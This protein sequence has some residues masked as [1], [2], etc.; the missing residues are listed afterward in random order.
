[1]MR[2]IALVGLSTSLLF[3]LSAAL[4]KTAAAG[5]WQTFSPR[6][7]APY[8]AD[9]TDFGQI[10]QAHSISSYGNGNLYMLGCDEAYQYNAHVYRYDQFG[11]GDFADVGGGYLQYVS[12]APSG[13]A[14]GVTNYLDG[15]KVWFWDGWNWRP[16]LLPGAR[17]AAG[18]AA[19]DDSTAFV[20]GGGDGDRCPG[21][22]CVYWT[23]NAGQSWALW[24]TDYDGNVGAMDIVYDP[25]TSEPW[26]IEDSG[27]VFAVGNDPYR[28]TFLYDEGV[29]G[30]PDNGSLGALRIAAANGQP[31]VIANIASNAG[32]PVF[33]LEGDQWSQVGTISN[34]TDISVD[35]VNGQ[36]WVIVLP[37]YY[38]PDTGQN[39][40][41]WLDIR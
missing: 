28:G 21:G 4:A 35:P 12:V 36:P 38:H 18:V 3:G 39:I 14:W 5:Q 32:G 30:L 7:G 33:R 37:D 27:H 15:G 6:G 20:L 16:R 9:A 2:K 8:C 26:F 17:L 13:R 24:T 1:M 10:G 23:Q 19:V 29:A 41:Y 34:A 25:S 11:T 31:W 40:L 22:Y